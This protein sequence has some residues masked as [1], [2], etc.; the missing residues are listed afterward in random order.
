MM[1]EP[2]YLFATVSNKMLNGMATTEFH[3]KIGYEQVLG[4]YETT[5]SRSLNRLR[6][7]VQKEVVKNG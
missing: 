2:M 6:D 5:V 7:A 4:I 1:F 3:N